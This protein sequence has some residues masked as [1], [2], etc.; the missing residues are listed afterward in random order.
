MQA[1]TS[2]AHSLLVKQASVSLAFLLFSLCCQGLVISCL[3]RRDATECA[4]AAAAALNSA[5]NLVSLLQIHHI[6]RS[7]SGF[8][9]AYHVR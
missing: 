8:F 2:N 7:V 3:V 4:A 1:L 5:S 6:Q 9:I